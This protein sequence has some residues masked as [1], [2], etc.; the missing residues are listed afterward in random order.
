M[1]RSVITNTSL[2]SLHGLMLDAKAEKEPCIQPYFFFPVCREH[3]PVLI[4]ACCTCVSEASGKKHLL[5]LH[6][7]CSPWPCC[8]NPSRA[9][10]GSQEAAWCSAACSRGKEV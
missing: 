7:F 10:Q 5:P 9:Q 8:W 6:G 1:H 2:P 3:D 4:T